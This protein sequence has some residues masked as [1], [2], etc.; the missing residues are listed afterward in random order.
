MIIF[1][2]LIPVI[3]A[4][5]NKISGTQGESLGPDGSRRPGP[6]RKPD[7]ETLRNYTPDLQIGRN[8]EKYRQRWNDQD[9]IRE[10]IEYFI[11]YPAAITG[12][13]TDQH[14]H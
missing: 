5:I 6:G 7:K 1:N 10:C 2:D 8:N 11:H 4:E 13:E 14:P 3:L 12:Y 9:D